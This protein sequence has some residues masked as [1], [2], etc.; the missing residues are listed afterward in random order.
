MCACVEERIQRANTK[1]IFYGNVHIQHAK[2]FHEWSVHIYEHENRT[3]KN[4]TTQ[5]DNNNNNEIITFSSNVQ[6]L[7][8]LHHP[9][10]R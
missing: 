5:N 3:R 9:T 1:D 4:K 10:F 8:T 2:R 7:E 6:T